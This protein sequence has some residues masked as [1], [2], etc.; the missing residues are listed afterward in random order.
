MEPAC[1]VMEGDRRRSAP[2]GRWSSLGAGAT[3]LR[4]EGCLTQ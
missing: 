4:E 1:S 3:D 2:T